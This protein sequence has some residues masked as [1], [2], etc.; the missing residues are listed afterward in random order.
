MGVAT[1]SAAVATTAGFAF[2][3]GVDHFRK[4]PGSRVLG[5]EEV[6]VT[7]D[8]E[9]SRFVPARVVVRPHTTVRFKVVNHDPIAHE[10][11]V[12]DAEVHARHA[13]GNHAT[14]GEVLGE[15][16]VGPGATAV[17][18]YQFHT[19]GTVLFACHLPRHLEYGMVGEV[20]VS[21]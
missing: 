14:H 15:V 16:S 1:L 8:V 13:S 7:L 4:S 18:T 10:L 6:T 20:E 21:P 5:P 17:T 9:H 3:S 12:G 11:I 19:P 2:A